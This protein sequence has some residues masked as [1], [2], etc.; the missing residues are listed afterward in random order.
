MTAMVPDTLNAQ[1]ATEDAPEHE[2]CAICQDVMDVPDAVVPLACGHKFHGTCQVR[3]MYESTSC[4]ICRHDPNDQDSSDEE[5]E[6]EEPERITLR[7]A[8]RMA[9]N[10][11]AS[12]K[13]I[14]RMFATLR[15]HKDNGKE[16][17]KKLRELKARMRPHVD[18]LEK[19]I[20]EY[21]EKAYDA[22]DRR[23]KKTLDAMSDARKSI[24]KSHT[25]VHASKL[26]IAA[27]YGYVR[28]AIRGSYRG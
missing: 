10:D 6:N 24:N 9:K 1:Q 4:P 7:E 23:H 17:H 2:I 3:Y 21:S 16:A 15:A 20:D 25:Q 13:T 8:L 28:R 26:R 5:D 22:H 12:N 11:M 19:R 14:A 27:K 18:A